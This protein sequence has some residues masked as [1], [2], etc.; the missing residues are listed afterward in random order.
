MISFTYLREMNRRR[1]K[2]WHGDPDPWTLSDWGN[3]LAGEVGEACNV[4]KKMRRLEMGMRQQRSQFTMEEFRVMLGKE[5]ADSFL[6]LD[7]LAEAAGIDLEEAIVAKF[8][9]VSERE[10]FDE[11]RLFHSVNLQNRQLLDFGRKES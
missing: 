8:N 1:K 3:A 2:L 5:L 9:E 4:I 10:G 11:M 6:Y 7:L